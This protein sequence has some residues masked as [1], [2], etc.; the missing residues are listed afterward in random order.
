M[1]AWSERMEAAN[2]KLEAARASGDQAAVEQAMKE[3]MA[4]LAANPATK[5]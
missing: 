1:E 2:K 3:T 5:P 4:L